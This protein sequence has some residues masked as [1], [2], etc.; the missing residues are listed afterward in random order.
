MHKRILIKDNRVAPAYVRH[1]ENMQRRNIDD[2]F[3]HIEDLWQRMRRATSESCVIWVTPE[4]VKT[5]Q[6]DRS[7]SIQLRPIVD[8]PGL[9][10]RTP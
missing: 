2:D 5:L 9:M 7:P 8:Y 6:D 4:Q 10:S 1:G 3:N